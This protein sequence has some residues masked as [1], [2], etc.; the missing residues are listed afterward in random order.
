MNMSDTPQKPTHEET[1]LNQLWVAMTGASA[2][3]GEA[4]PGLD[5]KA[6]AVGH[7]PDAFG[8]KGIVAIPI[9]IVLVLIM[10]Y[11][12]VTGVFAYVKS[13]QDNLAAQG[14][15]PYNERVGRISSTDPH[16]VDGQ[17]NTAVPQP[18][19][20]Y[21][22]QVED[23]RPG[24]TQVDPPY[25]RSFA[26]AEGGNNPPEIYPQYFLPENFVDPTS[27]KKSLLES[28][29]VSKEKGIAQI[30]IKDAI[31]ILT[32]TKKPKTGAAVPVIGTLG[33][34]KLSTGGRGGPSEPPAPPKN[35]PH[36]HNH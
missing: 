1:P 21:M 29:W 2:G 6:A 31:M 35:A 4:P 8:L 3:H 25:L 36:N 5:D 19:L 7:E 24:Q 28:E 30:S 18:R 22:K 33:Q 34:A 13:P 14:Q 23:T 9:A 26:P 32:T 12:V 15:K 20:E 10:T 17:A 27:G 11:L 16:A